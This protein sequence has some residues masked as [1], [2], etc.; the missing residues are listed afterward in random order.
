[1]KIKTILTFCLVSSSA[2]AALPPQYERARVMTYVI[3]QAADIFSGV[4]ISSIDLIDEADFALR[5]EKGCSAKVRVIFG[6][7]PEAFVGPAPM[8][9]LEILSEDCH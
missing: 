1:M 8:K 9:K 4:P 2:F 7:T 3:N 5:S 6:Q